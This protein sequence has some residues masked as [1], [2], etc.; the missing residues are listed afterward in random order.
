MVSTGGPNVKTVKWA[1]ALFDPR[2]LTPHGISLTNATGQLSILLL[3]VNAALR[4]FA[5]CY[6][7]AQRE[8]GVCLL[9][10]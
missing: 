4:M 3:H 6:L 9:P 5:E 7:N 1:Q 10:R 8:Q 2:F